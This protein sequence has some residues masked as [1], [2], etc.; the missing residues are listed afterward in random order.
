MAYYPRTSRNRDETDGYTTGANM[1]RAVGDFGDLM[2]QGQKIEATDMALEDER[3]IRQAYDYFAGRL[4]QGGDI[5]MLDGDPALN[6]RHGI[7]ALGKL[8][9]DRANTQASRV[10]MLEQMAQADDTLYTNYFRPLASQAQEAYQAGD[11]AKFGQIVQQLSQVSPFP[12]QYHMGQDGNFVESFRSNSANGYVET[13]TKMTPQQVMQE[14]TDIM[15]GEQNILRGADMQ[16][17]TVNPY[18]LASAARYRMA[19]I[20]GNAEALA[21]PKSWIPMVKDGKV[22]YAIPQN[23]HTDYSSGPAFRVLDEGAGTSRMVKSLDDLVQQGYVPAAAKA[24]AQKATGGGGTPGSKTSFGPGSKG[25]FNPLHQVL[26]GAGYIWDKDQKAYFKATK[27]ADGKSVPDYQQPLTQDALNIAMHKAKGGSGNAS[28]PL[29]LRGRTGSGSAAGVT[30][31]SGGQQGNRPPKPNIPQKQNKSAVGSL[32]TYSK[33]GKQQWAVI[34]EDGSPRDLTPEEVRAYQDKK[35]VPDKPS[36]P[37]QKTVTIN[38][39]WKE[40]SPQEQENWRKTGKLPS[41]YNQVR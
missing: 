2:A 11:M 30:S 32:V 13:G 24:K 4:G 36:S 31:G 40:L 19:T 38:D 23:S 9:Q 25:K 26:I 15:S 3:G 10:K 1:L 7:M 37:R 29:G 39:V 8:T 16:T 14:I 28:D 34:G 20:M 21:N 18:F 17:H 33:N 22:V 35:L 5:S 12:Y 6:T 41:R 27:D